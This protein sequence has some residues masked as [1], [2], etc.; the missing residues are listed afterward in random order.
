MVENKYRIIATVRP[1]QNEYEARNFIEKIKK[2]I[3][4]QG[5]MYLHIKFTK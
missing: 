1:V 5:I 2:D 3:G 4:M